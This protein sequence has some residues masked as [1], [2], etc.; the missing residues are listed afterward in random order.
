MYVSK[1]DRITN[2]YNYPPPP[3][4]PRPAVWG[5]QSS[6]NTGSSSPRSN[7]LTFN[8]PYTRKRTIFEFLP[9]TDGTQLLSIWA[10]L[11]P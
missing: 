4:L 5:T 7:P 2:G 6:F 11:G 9:L 3:P 10:M 1:N 8:I